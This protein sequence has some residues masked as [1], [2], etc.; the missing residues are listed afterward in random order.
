MNV[1]DRTYA[2]AAIASRVCSASLCE[3]DLD[4]MIQIVVGVGV[5]VAFGKSVDEDAG[6]WGLKL[7][8]WVGSVM[9]VNGQESVAYGKM[10]LGVVL[11]HTIGPRCC[12]RGRRIVALRLDFITAVEKMIADD[13]VNLHASEEATPCLESSEDEQSERNAYGGVDTILNGAEDGDEDA[14]KEDDNLK[15]RNLPE[16]VD[17]SWRGD[18]I[19]N[20]VNNDRGEGGIRNVEE[21]GW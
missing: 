13:G 1:R 3:D 10:M 19:T 9:V 18:Q 16:A 2:E 21:N 6:V 17:N 11:A 5:I 12:T 8:C 4:Q 15:G 20:G 7:D 14:S